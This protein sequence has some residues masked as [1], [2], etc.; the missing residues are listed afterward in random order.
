M[1]L[2]NNLKF[3]NTEKSDSDSIW[4]CRKVRLH[5]S[6]YVHIQASLQYQTF[7]LS[8]RIC[9]HSEKWRNRKRCSIHSSVLGDTPFLSRGYPLSCLRVLP[10]LFRQRVP[11]VL[12]W[13][14]PMSC[15]ESG[16]PCSVWGGGTTCLGGTPVLGPDWGAPSRIRVPPS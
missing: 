16:I 3:R 8:R 1:Y 13:G 9:C 7:W 15:P 4:G 5:I 10:V 12:S 11:P 2:L 14:Y 6:G